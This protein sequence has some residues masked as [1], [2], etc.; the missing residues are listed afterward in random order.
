[1]GPNEAGKTTLLQ[2]LTQLGTND[3]VSPSAL[4]RSRR[5]SPEEYAVNAEYFLEA[6]DIDELA[7][8]DLVKMPVRMTYARRIQGGV[9]VVGISPT[10][11]RSR[12]PFLA[13]LQTLTDFLNSSTIGTLDEEQDADESE[14]PSLESRVRSAIGFLAVDDPSLDD[15]T[16]EKIMQ[17]ASDLSADAFSPI[18]DAFHAAAS[19]LRLPDVEVE[20]RNRLHV[21]APR[22]LLFDE[23]DRELATSYDIQ[24]GV[25]ATPPASLANL[26][27]LARLDLVDLI[28]AINANDR[29]KVLTLQG[30]ANKQLAVEFRRAW[31]QSQITVELDVEGTV[32]HVHIKQD[33]DIVTSLDERSAGL[34]IFVALA[35][36]IATKPTTVSPILLI[37]EAETH[38]HYDAQ[39]NLVDVLLGQR[40]AA[41][42]I[43]TTHSPGCLPPD[44][45]TGIR[46]VQPSSEDRSISVVKNSFW[47]GESAGFSPLL[48]AMG[49]GAAAFTPSR[50]AVLAEGAS[51]MILMP[52]L[53]RAATGL[54]ELPYQIAPGLSESPIA[55]YP[56]LDLEGARVAFMVD[57][58]KGGRSLRKK[59]IASGVPEDYIAM[60]GGMTLE[61]AVDLDNYCKAVHVEAEAA[62]KTQVPRIPSD[63]FNADPRA[64]TVGNWYGKLSLRAPSKIAVA[65]RLVQDGLAIPSEQGVLALRQLHQKLTA[66]LKISQ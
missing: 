66:A 1:V 50:Y 39:A 10:P 61:D 62:N 64:T 31:R 25:A 21:R 14:P 7:D 18:R 11:V 19:W 37:D 20:T 59:L 36:F 55:S 56:D 23:A 27:S 35:A 8:L 24:G 17:V 57:G 48:L 53:I 26:A 3:P 58:D 22:F 52:S 46:V 5:P 38:L 54:A 15:A 2:A 63:A 44:L 6:A 43:Y 41:K 33:D 65:N 60:L 13:A 30:R 9:P 51:E 40:E 49:A 47:A 34:R 12:A 28:D 29:G 16:L 4:S 42:V 32:I 45:G